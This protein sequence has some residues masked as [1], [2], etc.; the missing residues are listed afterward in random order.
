MLHLQSWIISTLTHRKAACFKL[1]A[2]PISPCLFSKPGDLIAQ[3]TKQIS[4]KAERERRG[5]G[6]EHACCCRLTL[7]SVMLGAAQFMDHGQFIRS[8][9]VYQRGRRIEDGREW[10]PCRKPCFGII[11]AMIKMFP[12]WRKTAG[13]TNGHLLFQPNMKE[14]LWAAILFFFLLWAFCEIL[15]RWDCGCFIPQ[16]SFQKQFLAAFEFCMM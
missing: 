5:G 2:T 8:N 4:A 15:R 14:S 11:Y 6:S 16:F 3:F 10:F 12:L 13:S 9:V 1:F 7:C